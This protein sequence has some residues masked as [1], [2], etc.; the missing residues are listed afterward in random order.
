MKYVLLILILLLGFGLVRQI[1][2]QSASSNCVTTRIGS[3]AE[4]AAVPSNCKM[5]AEE[6]GGTPDGSLSPAQPPQQGI[7]DNIV[8]AAQQVKAAYDKCAGDDGYPSGDTHERPGLADCL[9]EYYTSIGYS[10][11]HADT[12][13]IRRGNSLVGSPNPQTYTANCTQCLGFVGVVAALWTNNIEDGKTLSYQ[14]ASEMAN[15]ESFYVGDNL[16]Q[17]MGFGIEVDVQPGDI[18]IRG[19]QP[20]AD[21]GGHILIVKEKKGNVS[22]YAI[23]SNYEV[24]CR[25]TDDRNWIKEDFAFFRKQ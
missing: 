12:V 21:N 13:E 10:A 8:Q 4:E 24:T 9:H 25:I 20:C 19:G 1:H 3:P 14:C 15:L 7:A 6:P 11:E 18:G 17:R 16:F 23:E 2:A 5:S 22:F